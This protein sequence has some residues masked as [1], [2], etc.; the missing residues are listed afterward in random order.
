MRALAVLVA[1]VLLPTA[2]AAQHVEIA[3]FGGYRFGGDF[4]EY[5]SGSA[6]DADGGPAF[7]AACDVP[8]HDGLSL[9]FLYSR[10]VAHAYISTSAGSTERLSGSNEY[11]HAGGRQDFG[12]NGVRPF[13]TGTLGLTRLAMAGDS[14]V[15][16]S[17]GAGGGVTLRASNRVALR[18]DGRVIVTFTDA[19]GSAA[20]CGSGTCLTALHVSTLWQADFTAGVA[21]RL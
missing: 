12:A 1:C 19:S 18:L 17:L 9:E 20:V 15:R 8:L 5:L 6:Q 13:L 3:A 16:F 21:F 4:L 11:W 7:G 10:Q 2:A 14:E